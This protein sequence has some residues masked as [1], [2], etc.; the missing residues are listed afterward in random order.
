MAHI[1]GTINKIFCSPIEGG[2]QFGNTHR[3]S[4]YLE[5]VEGAFGFGSRKTDKLYIKSAGG[6]V[7]IGDEIEFMYQQNGKYKN[8]KPATVVRTKEATNR[9]SGTQSPVNGGQGRPQSVDNGQP[10]PAAVGQVLNLAVELKLINKLGELQDVN[11]ARAVV[12]EVKAAKAAIAAVW[13]D[14]EKQAEQDQQAA[15][16]HAE[17]AGGFDDD[18]PF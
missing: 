3:H 15:Q 5:G 10:N 16:S 18:L 8:A 7:R 17:P 11:V 14:A 1:S 4:V 9:D 2:D 6:E 12:A 13:N